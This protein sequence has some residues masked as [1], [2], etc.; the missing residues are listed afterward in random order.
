MKPHE[1][2]RRVGVVRFS[3]KSLANGELTVTPRYAVK[4]YGRDPNTR[5]PGIF[6]RMY[7]ARLVQQ[8]LNSK[9]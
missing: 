9:R 7:L 3:V 6:G 2:R 8:L 5:L 1:I 4:A